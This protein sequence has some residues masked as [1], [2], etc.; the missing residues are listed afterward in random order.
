[1]AGTTPSSFLVPFL[2]IL[3]L[4]KRLKCFSSCIWT[5]TSSGHG[6]GPALVRKA[7]VSKSDSRG[8]GGL[9]REE[10]A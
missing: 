7:E 3:H 2:S 8:Q 9:G 6:S 1:M 5:S 10:A 4:T